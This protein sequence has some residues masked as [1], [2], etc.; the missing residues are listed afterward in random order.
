MLT[1]SA[2]FPL[3]VPSH[4]RKKHANVV[5]RAFMVG[6]SMERGLCEM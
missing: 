2:L 3:L 5:R 4:P 1:F 6:L